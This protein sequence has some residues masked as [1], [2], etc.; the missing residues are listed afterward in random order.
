VRPGHP[1]LERWRRTSGRPSNEK[2]DSV[3]M[4]AAA[5]ESVGGVSAAGKICGVSRQSVYLWIREWRIR[6]IWSF[7]KLL[8]F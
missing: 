4:V 1:V 7:Q 8:T 3:N 6:K 5:V 2:A